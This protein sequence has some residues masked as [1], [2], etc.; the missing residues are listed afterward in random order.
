MTV[1]RIYK[2]IDLVFD[3]LAFI[4]M[5]CGIILCIVPILF[6]ELLASTE[7]KLSVCSAMARAA[8]NAHLRIVK[9]QLKR[10]QSQSVQENQEPQP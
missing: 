10:H 6:F 7:L 8:A 1:V 9:K 5:L 3:T 4:F 2:V